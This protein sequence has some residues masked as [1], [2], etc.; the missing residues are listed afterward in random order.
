M[1]IELCSLGTLSQYALEVF[2]LAEDKS[3]E[4]KSIVQSEIKA[5]TDRLE[6]LSLKLD[7]QSLEASAKAP[8][9]KPWWGTLLEFLALPAAILA[10]VFQ[11]VQT[12]GTVGTGAK[13]EA[14]TEKIKTEEIK[15]RVELQ[16]LLDSIAEKRQQGAEAYKNEIEKTLPKLQETVERLKALEAQSNRFLIES[17]LAKFVL[18]WI[19]FHA[20]GLV[21]DIFS[22]LWST[23]LSGGALAIFNRKLKNRDEKS[24]EKSERVR[25]LTTWAVAVLSPVPSILR[26]SVQLSIF[27]ALM[28]PLFDEIS[29]VLG[30]DITFQAV[31]NSAK[32]LSIGDAIGKVRLILFGS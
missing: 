18:L 2:K 19:I 28:V 25:K 9:T 16:V 15:T 5:L 1:T 32:S 30:S 31:F 4:P 7:K 22:Q 6:I 23:L 11:I 3:N 26:W 21:F 20:V 10:I 12:T 17:T 29:R 24:R 13:T 14:E 27:I 8:A